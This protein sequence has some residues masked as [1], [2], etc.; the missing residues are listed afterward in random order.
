MAR[1]RDQRGRGHGRRDEDEHR[2]GA[3]HLRAVREP[4][5]RLNDAPCPPFASHGA[6]ISQP[7]GAGDH[8]GAADAGLRHPQAAP[9][10]SGVSAGS[11]SKVVTPMSWSDGE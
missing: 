7:F 10:D 3:R 2:R 6:S 1:G 5:G 9:P 4:D 8:G 11:P